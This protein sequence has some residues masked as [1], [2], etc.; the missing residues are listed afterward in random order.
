M[1]TRTR[2]PFQFTPQIAGGALADIGSVWCT[3]NAI[4]TEWRVGL[5]LCTAAMLLGGVLYMGEKK[6]SKFWMTL[7]RYATVV[8]VALWFFVM[9]KDSDSVRKGTSQCSSKLEDI[10]EEQVRARGA[11]SRPAPR[12]VQ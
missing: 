12:C 5:S 7:C 3:F 8:S 6:G 9:C 11:G 10:I 2:Q 4:N 1:H